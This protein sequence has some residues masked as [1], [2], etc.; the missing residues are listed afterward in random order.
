MGKHP[1]IESHGYAPKTR[2][3]PLNQRTDGGTL[4][5]ARDQPNSEEWTA[6]DER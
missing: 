3:L 6:V 2:L 1:D 5:W 4:G